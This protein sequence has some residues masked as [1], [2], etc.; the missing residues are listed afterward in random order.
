MAYDGLCMIMTAMKNNF[1]T[2]PLLASQKRIRHGFFTRRG[3]HSSGQY[4][5]LNCGF[6]SGDDLAV[7]ARN[8]AEVGKALGVPGEA[9]CTAY[10]IHSPD[11]VTLTAP[12]HWE[13]AQEADALVTKTPGVALGVLTA[14]C[15]PVLFA[16]AQAGVIGAAHAGW[17]GAFGGVLENTVK[18]MQGLGAAPG[19]I[20]AAI[21]PA[22]Q[23]PSYEVGPE[24][25]DRLVAAE[26]AN[27]RYFTPSPK[28]GHHLFNLPEYVKNRLGRMGLGAINLLASDTCSGEDDFFSF[29][30]ATL[31]GEP[32]YGRHVS[33]IIL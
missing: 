13:D 33:A 32:V 8:R 30:R 5:S 14:D 26:S 10:Q 2:D 25:Y 11:V 24:F 15:V 19:R 20:T 31:R 28:P 6:C 7:V 22:I 17:K 18:A 3:G 12:W 27:T 23:Q 9:L 1:L 29:R 16:D 21:G 4:T